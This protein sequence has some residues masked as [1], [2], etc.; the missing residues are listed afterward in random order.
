MEDGVAT[1]VETADGG[2]F[3]AK[4]VVSKIG[5]RETIDRL[6]PDGHGHDDWANEIRSIGPGPPSQ[7][8]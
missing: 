3:F 5:A 1:G 6:L 4:H 8:L 2:K 7:V